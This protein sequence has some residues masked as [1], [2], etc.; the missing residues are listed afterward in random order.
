MNIVHRDIKPENILLRDI[1]DLSSLVLVDFGLSCTRDSETYFKVCGTPGY[2]APEILNKMFYLPFEKIDVFSLGC[3]FYELLTEKFLFHAKSSKDTTKLNTEC[4]IDF[5]SKEL[6]V[7]SSSVRSLMQ[8]MLEKDPN[9]RI[10]VKEAM[11]HNLIAACAG[12]TS[13]LTT[14][15][16]ERKSY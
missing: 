4:L 7:V 2:I 8:M 13:N 6:K 15:M 10:S 5:D 9:K 11:E 16:T 14:L 12:R 3:I 1:N